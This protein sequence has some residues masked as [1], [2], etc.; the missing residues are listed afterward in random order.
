MKT[1]P[2][3]GVA[4]GAVLHFSSTALGFGRLP[5]GQQ[6][7]L[8]LQVKN[9]GGEAGRVELRAEP[10]FYIEESEVGFTLAPG[11]AREVQVRCDAPE[12]GIFLKRLA[13]AGGG[14]EQSIALAAE[15][16]PEAE[17]RWVLR[18][19]ELSIQ[20]SESTSSE[21]EVPPRLPSTA[22]LPPLPAVKILAL[23]RHVVRLSWPIKGD[24]RERLEV[25]WLILNMKRELEV[26]WIPIEKTTPLGE[27]NGQRLVEV[28]ELEVG[29]FYT[30][31]LVA[32]DEGGQPV[33]ASPLVS[34]FTPP[35]RRLVPSPFSTLATLLAILLAGIAWRRWQGWREWQARM[36]SHF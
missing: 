1:V 7:A 9:I 28:P 2:V 29:T 30:F 32:L 36:R 31:R 6:S 4:V 19:S 18:G 33:A 8:P 14:Q 22:I 24:R 12:V 15:V 26:Q 3:R 16:T 13:V 27:N 5:R 10:P 11:N 25:R 35:G 20:K 21:A 34:F 23:A 17:S